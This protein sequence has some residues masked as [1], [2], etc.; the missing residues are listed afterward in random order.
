M[1]IMYLMLYINNIKYGEVQKKI[2][3]SFMYLLHI[4]I[5]CVYGG[6]AAIS[7]FYKLISIYISKVKKKVNDGE[8]ISVRYHNPYRVVVRLIEKLS[9]HW[10]FYFFFYLLIIIKYWNLYYILG[11]CIDKETHNNKYMR[12]WSLVNL[13]TISY[14]FN[15]A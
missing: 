3:F 2:I 7:M 6:T 13:L 14:A 1:Y 11:K 9:R 12:H 10:H 4:G 8:T 15:I 5:Y